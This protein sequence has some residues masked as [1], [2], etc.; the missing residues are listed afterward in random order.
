MKSNLGNK[1]GQHRW[2]KGESGNPNG[3]PKGSLCLTTLLKKE[4]EKLS[5]DE[6]LTWAQRIAKAIPPATVN[7]LSGKGD[8]RLVEFI[9]ERIDGKVVLPVGGPDGGPIAMT[10]VVTSPKAKELVKKTMEG[11][12]TD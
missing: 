1:L 9:F 10:V 7:A 11:H 12:G 8:S 6:E 4:L 3:R 2:K 5:D